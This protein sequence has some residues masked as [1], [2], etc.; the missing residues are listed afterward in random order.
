[1]ASYVI[2]SY[3]WTDQFCIAVLAMLLLVCRRLEQ[4]EKAHWLMWTIVAQMVFIVTDALWMGVYEGSVSSDRLSLAGAT[5]LS[6][7]ALN[8][9]TYISFVY[10]TLRER[11]SISKTPRRRALLA[12]PAVVATAYDSLMILLGPLGDSSVAGSGQAVPYSIVGLLCPSAYLLASLVLSIMGFVKRDNQARRGVFLVLILYPLIVIVGIFLQMTLREV[13]LYGPLV[14]VSLV[15]YFITFAVERISFDHLTGMMSRGEFIRRVQKAVRH[16]SCYAIM[17]DMNGLKLAND[18]YG[19]EEGDQM[20]ATVGRA[21]KDVF[22]GPGGGFIC[23]YGGDEFLAVVPSQNDQDAQ[24]FI[25][26]ARQ[27]IARYAV[28]DGLN[29]IPEVAMGF[30][31][32][33]ANGD[34]TEQIAHADARMY[35]DKR[36]MKGADREAGVFT[37][38]VTGLPNGNYFNTVADKT[39]EVMRKGGRWPK[40]LF[41]D[42]TDMHAYNERYGYGAGDELLRATSEAISAQFPGELVVRYT[43][44]HFVA[45]TTA[46]DIRERVDVVGEAVRK[47]SHGRTADLRVGVYEAQDPNDSASYCLDKARLAKSLIRTDKINR[48]RFYDEEAKVFFE[49]KDYVLGHFEQALREGWI[50]P[51][52]QPQI[53]TLTDGVCG[54]EA[55]ARWIDPTHGL[56][57][58]GTFVGVLE[59]ARLIHRLDLEVIRRVCQSIAEF[60]AKGIATQ[61]VSV[62]LSRVDFDVCDIFAEVDKVRRSFGVRPSLLNIEVTESTIAGSAYPVHLALRNFRAAGYEIWMDDFGSDYSSLGNL[63]DFHFDVIKIDRSFLSDAENS[64][65]ARTILASTI[66]MAK[67]LGTHTLCEGVETMDQRDLLHEYGCEYQQGYLYMKPSPLQKMVELMESAG[68]GVYEPQHEDDYYEAI[69]LVNVLTDP[70]IDT[71]DSHGPI[72]LP[73]SIV[74]YRVDGSMRRLYANDA[75]KRKIGTGVVPR[76]MSAQNHRDFLK[77]LF[78][79]CDELQTTCT[80]EYLTKGHMTGV[81]ARCIKKEAN[82]SAYVCVVTDLGGTE[83]H[84]YDGQDGRDGGADGQA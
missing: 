1:M 74:E 80:L 69:G 63:K 34:L 29:S 78:A 7:L 37:D 76:G 83:Q 13:P 44:D 47:A 22:S 32:L 77:V 30:E 51:Y 84:L 25:D 4:N 11:L 81:R 61:P 64:L 67:R 19:H 48:C 60:E 39:L 14:T 38:G 55:L 6:G 33:D 35:A 23:R 28:E 43:E 27:T 71:L 79:Q 65:A 5:A 72:V 20:I 54:S 59:D 66:S 58:P 16:G 15:Y 46:A 12:I 40:V 17:A 52:Y 21:L 31:R 68:P 53:R 62:N 9:S 18:I 50:Q 82:R 42:V 8:V 10:M 36:Q 26:R 73:L 75:F 2:T 49:R 57:M 56:M 24:D 41:L 45:L 3:L 70:T